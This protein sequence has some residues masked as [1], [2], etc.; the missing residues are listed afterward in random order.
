HQVHRNF[1]STRCKG[2]KDNWV[3]VY[4]ISGVRDGA[5]GIEAPRRHRFQEQR[6]SPRI[7]CFRRGTAAHLAQL[8]LRFRKD[9]RHGRELRVP[10]PSQ[11][12]H[13]DESHSRRSRDDSSRLAEFPKA[14]LRRRSGQTLRKDTSEIAQLLLRCHHLHSREKHRRRIRSL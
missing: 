5:R 11:F 8:R 14:L 7:R 4:T 13:W 12:R 2:G 9:A 6:S 10:R 1:L 3:D